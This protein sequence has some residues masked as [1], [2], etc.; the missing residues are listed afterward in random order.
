MMPR[1]R[2]L[3]LEKR[4]ALVERV[5]RANIEAGRLPAGLVLL[6][7]PI[8][9]LLQ[10]SRAPVQTALQKLEADGL[11]HRFDGRGYLVGGGTKISAPMRI[12]IRRLGLAIPDD[13]DEALQ[14]RGSWE[15]IYLAV[16]E[17]VAS[18][19]IFGE[20][21]IIET[22]IA[23][24][25]NVSRTVVRDVLGRLQER[26]LVRKNQSSHWIAGPLTAQSIKER[27]ELRRILE[28]AALLAAAPFIDREVIVALRN[29]AVAAEAGSEEIASWEELE[30][31]FMAHC[32]FKAPNGQLTETI[33]QN[34]LPL[35]AANRL[36]AQLG[37]PSDP[38]AV[39][40]IRII[41]DLILTDAI[42]SAAEFLRDHLAMTG[43]RTIARLKIVAVIPEPRS[44]A[45]Y[46]T[47]V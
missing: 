13:V 35:D 10:T 28:S 8:A 14:S 46:L 25:F 24:Y 39:T 44:L 22:E 38:I 7:R 15:R 1:S 45:P 12:D 41:L 32:I 11:I 26:G 3:P 47:A 17:A 31:T 18:C 21:R 30:A 42:G 34:K 2:E 20:Y 36:L 27:Y 29:R 16:E 23:F 43:E 4:Y 9:E 40:E 5:L 6:E 37:L 19:L 33:R